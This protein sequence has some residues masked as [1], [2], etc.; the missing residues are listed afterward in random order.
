L[1]KAASAAGCAAF[2]HGR[3]NLSVLEDWISEH[4]AELEAQQDGGGLRDQKLKEEIRK[5]RIQNDAKAGK[6]V[7][8]SEV[9]ETHDRILSR[10]RGD[11]ERILVHELPV[12]CAGQD[13]AT[14]RI[15]CRRYADMAV[16][17]M[18]QCAEE[19]K[20]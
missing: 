5:L 2:D 9:I 19:W 17:A 1:V 8:R 12:A 15:V 10:M 18:Q 16:A 6:L 13:V 11:L 14:A 3:V 7:A 20:A 4:A